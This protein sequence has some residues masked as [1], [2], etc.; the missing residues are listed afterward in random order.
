MFNGSLEE[1]GNKVS[2]FDVCD[3]IENRERRGAR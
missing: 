1:G 3:V 2:V